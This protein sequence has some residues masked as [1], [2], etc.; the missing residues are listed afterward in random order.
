MKPW[1][2]L[3]IV[4]AGLTILMLLV[5]QTPT[6]V[7]LES[8][9]PKTG[10]K[11]PVIVEL[12]T[13][14]GCSSCPPADRVLAEL[15][16]AQPVTNAIIIALGEHVDYWND[17]GWADPFSSGAFSERQQTYARAFNTDTYTPQMVVDGQAEFVGNDS[18]KAISAIS[19]AARTQKANLQ[20]TPV[21][22]ATI[23][24][25]ATEI[26]AQLNHAKLDIVL[27]LTESHLQTKVERGENAGRMLAHASVVRQLQVIGTAP[28]AEVK[29]RMEPQWKREN[30]KAV[31][32][33][34][35]RQSRRILGA[36]VQN[37]V[38]FRP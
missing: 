17:L 24:V 8:Q 14:E 7:P 23:K 31:A 10:Q 16:K 30:L 20:I 25:T 26:P 6:P 22:Q 33:L 32:F 38:E 9:A 36:T 4:I 5:H 37:L 21:N 11:V 27:A 34:Q 2:I 12:F 35:E 13:S 18:A 15:E 1:S 3:L 29:L 28:T 19:K